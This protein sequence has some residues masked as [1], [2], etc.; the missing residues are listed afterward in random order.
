MTAPRLPSFT[1]FAAMLPTAG[2]PI[3]IHASKFYMDE[4]GV[5]LAA[6]GA[7]LFGVRLL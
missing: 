1:F 7:V 4:Y 3:Y 5:S 2:L 6:L